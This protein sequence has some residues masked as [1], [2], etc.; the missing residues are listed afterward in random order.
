MAKTL[1]PRQ[2]LDLAFLDRVTPHLSYYF[3]LSSLWNACMFI[4][5]TKTLLKYQSL[6]FWSLSKYTQINRSYILGIIYT[7]HHFGRATFKDR[8]LLL[9]YLQ[10]PIILS[11]WRRCHWIISGLDALG[12][13]VWG[14]WPAAL[15]TL[16]APLSELAEIGG[17]AKEGHLTRAA[18]AQVECK[19]M[20][21]Q[22]SFGHCHHHQKL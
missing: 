7:H 1:S 19:E 9:S 12:Y 18:K 11:V 14:L 22:E 20:G 6:Y 3:H 13:S 15:S 17:P 10:Y 5:C 8:W 2:F 16:N 4:L 21:K